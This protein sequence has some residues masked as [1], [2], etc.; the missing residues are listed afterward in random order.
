MKNMEGWGHVFHNLLCM[1]TG[2]VR[3]VLVCSEQVS[4]GIPPIELH[5]DTGLK[6]YIN[7]V[8]SVVYYRAKGKNFKLL[9][10]YF[11]FLR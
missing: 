4:S 3:T 8:T 2:V 7:V 5:C 11:F 6:K 1:E 9:P 10:K